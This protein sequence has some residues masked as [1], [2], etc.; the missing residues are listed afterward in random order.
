[1]SISPGEGHELERA[2]SEAR[3]V[4]VADATVS[5]PILPI[6]LGIYLVGYAG[7]SFEGMFEPLRYVIYLV[8]L[9]LIGAAM[10][11]RSP[12][13]SNK[14]AVAFLV[15]YLAMALISSLT[16]TKGNEFYLRNFVI[17]TLITLTF[18][19]IVRV[20]AAQIRF[21]FICSLVFLILAYL[22]SGSGSIRLLRMLKDGSGSA[23][24]AGFDN[25][26]GG[27][28]GAPYA[29]FLYAIG[30]KFYFLLAFIMSVLGG[31]RVGIAAIL[32]GIVATTVFRNVAAL[33]QPRYRFLALASVLATI[34]LVAANLTAISEYWHQILYTG[35]HIEE[36]ML[37]RYAIGQEI[38]TAIATRPFI[39][40][41]FGSGPGGADTLASIVSDGVLTQP[42]ND[43]LKILYDYG[44]V[45]SIAMTVLMALV[46][47]TSATG[48]VL[49][50]T[51]ATMMSTDNVLIYLFY[52]IP[53]AL[54]VAYSA[55]QESSQAE[56]AAT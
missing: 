9:L 41:L 36:V 52:Q 53:I 12:M 20:T 3:M 39:E 42:H 44:I 40:S 16:A 19:P 33:K 32:V 28:V 10:L 35:V 2:M 49:A 48:S 27:L 34:N 4:E 18:I 5:P 55:R 14:P 22:Q 21:I 37:G 24:E 6:A 1:M 30:A 23:L 45:G 25:N 13:M 56:S 43:W 8:P 47:S 17:I 26:Q 11:Q 46:F 51:S 15:G 50:I 31:K 7:Y 54:M 29:V 38:E